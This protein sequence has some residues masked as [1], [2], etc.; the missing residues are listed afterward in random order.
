MMMILLLTV[1]QNKRVW[2]DAQSASE[3]IL[4][5]LAEVFRKQAGWIQ[6]RGFHQVGNKYSKLWKTFTLCDNEQNINLL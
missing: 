3:V 2:G 5:D 4:C 6:L 1:V